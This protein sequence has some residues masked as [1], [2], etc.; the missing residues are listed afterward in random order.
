MTSIFLKEEINP[1]KLAYAVRMALRRDWAFRITFFFDDKGRICFKDNTSDP[2]VCRDDGQFFHFGSADTAGYLFI[3]LYRENKI[4]LRAFHGLTD[5]K[6]FHYFL[7][8]I[9]YYYLEA[10]GKPV[11][12]AEVLLTHDRPEDPSE[13]ALSYES[14]ADPG[15]SSGY[16]SRQKDLFVIPEPYDEE[17]VGQTRVENLAIPIESILDFAH[18]AN[19]TIT[20]VLMAAIGQAIAQT[21]SVGD[22]EIRAVCTVDKRKLWNV[23][24]LSNFSGSVIVPYEHGLQVA[25]LEKQCSAQNLR[26]KTCNTKEEHAF[27][28]AR[29]M[30]YSKE[31][32]EYPTRQAAAVFRQKE[33]SS[34]GT[35][36]ISNVGT[37][38]Y[39]SCIDREVVKI[40][41]G[42][43]P[44]QTNMRGLAFAASS[45]DGALTV[46]CG[47]C[48]GNDRLLRKLVSVLED[49]GLP[50]RFQDLGWIA[51]DSL[52][53]TYCEAHPAQE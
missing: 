33:L 7:Q 29:A 45:F 48:Y 11:S 31:I 51:G 19:S 30:E 13:W 49:A 10:M 4:V 18:R 8:S 40:G 21:Y 47:N 53:Y 24:A 43:P 27:Q 46:S 41:S 5:G 17:R 28:A 35:Y 1:E 6:G 15:A 2:V 44:M 16:P 42:M 32:R 34:P 9:L 25:P 52:D 3:V 26:L 36:L 37:V 12:S 50:V 39:G 38:S 23:R 22:R 20:S 14:T